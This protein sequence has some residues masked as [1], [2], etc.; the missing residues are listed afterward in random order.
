[1]LL[2]ALLRQKAKKMN[3][4]IKVGWFL[5]I[6]FPKKH[7]FSLLLSKIEIL[8]GILGADVVGF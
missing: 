4:R 5:Y 3:I 6:L 1:M 8:N 2:L 7:F